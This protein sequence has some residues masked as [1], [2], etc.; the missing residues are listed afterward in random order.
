MLICFAFKCGGKQ[1]MVENISAP[2]SDQNCFKAP[3]SC[4]NKLS[5]NYE[6]QQFQSENSSAWLGPQL[7]NTQVSLS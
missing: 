2:K 1:Q 6:S 3:Q 7:W 5:E 4:F